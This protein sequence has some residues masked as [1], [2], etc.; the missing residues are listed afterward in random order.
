MWCQHWAGAVLATWC[1]WLADLLS[2]V[3]LPLAAVFWVV[4]PRPTWAITVIALAALTDLLDGRVARYARRHGA[5]RRVEIGG[6]L[7]PL[8]DKVFAVTAL[9]ALIVR[10]DTALELVGLIAARDLVMTPLIAIYVLSP[11]HRRH[12]IALR[13]SVAGKVTTAAQFVALIA[14]VADVD[15]RATFALALVAA[16]AGLYATAEYIV[17]AIRM[18]RLARRG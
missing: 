9:V 14:L 6:W 2:L 10:R 13:A 1:M 7:D 3:R 5:A 16:A 15:V 4:A 18:V 11:L 8:C 12:A 17:H